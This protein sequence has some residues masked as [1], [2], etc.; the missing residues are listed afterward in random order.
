MG[1]V[2]RLFPRNV[3]IRGAAQRALTDAMRSVDKLSGVVIVA[4]G[5][6]G[7][8]ALR[9]VRH[10]DEMHTFDLYSRAGALIDRERGKLIEL[11]S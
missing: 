8:F 11:D 2:V 3:H 7:T 1:K 5:K 6:N 4:V 9:D 10:V